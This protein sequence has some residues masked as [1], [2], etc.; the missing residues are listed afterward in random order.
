MEP[1]SKQALSLF[2]L[3]TA[4]IVFYMFVYSDLFLTVLLGFKGIEQSQINQGAVILETFFALLI[5]AGLVNICR[6]ILISSGSV[7]LMYWSTSFFQLISAGIVFLL[8]PA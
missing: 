7:E 3:A 2:T 1:L 6:K 4:P 8:V 5:V